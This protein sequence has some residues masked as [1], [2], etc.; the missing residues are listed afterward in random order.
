MVTFAIGFGSMVE[1]EQD[2]IECILLG[3]MM[4]CL[5]LDAQTLTKQKRDSSP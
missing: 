5:A 2:V 1:S 4:V 3:L